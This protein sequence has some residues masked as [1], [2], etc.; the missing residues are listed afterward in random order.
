[1]ASDQR[2]F[3]SNAINKTPVPGVQIIFCSCVNKTTVFSFLRLLLREKWQIAPLPEDIKK[4]IWW[5][6]DKTVIE[7]G[8]RKIALFASVS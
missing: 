5:S 4:Q 7:L 6:N 3:S 2:S 8:Y 1:M